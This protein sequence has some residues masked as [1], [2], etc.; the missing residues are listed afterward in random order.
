M[1]GPLRRTRAT[2]ARFGAGRTAS[3][4]VNDGGAVVSRYRAGRDRARRAPAR[5]VH[6][7]RKR[8]GL[9]PSRQ[10]ARAANR[11]TTAPWM[12]VALFG[13]GV[14]AGTAS[15]YALHLRKPGVTMGSHFR[16]SLGMRS[17][18][19][20][21]LWLRIARETLHT[22]APPSALVHG[23]RKSPKAGYLGKSGYCGINE[24][25]CFKR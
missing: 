11:K 20:R 8:G 1:N 9:K 10:V 25:P 22:P 19:L 5:H 18:K 12:S 13:K 23:V 24:L 2:Q 16:V 14:P 3:R 7:E 6:L 15:T 4:T 17:K 21:S